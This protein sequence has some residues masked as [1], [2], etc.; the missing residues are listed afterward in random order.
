MSFVLDGQRYVWA[1]DLPVDDPATIQAIV[2]GMQD[3]LALVL[4][5]H[6][7]LRARTM[8]S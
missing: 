7:V 4:R 2:R 6:E 1:S 3:R 5:E 8:E